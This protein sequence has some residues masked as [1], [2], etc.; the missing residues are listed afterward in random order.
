MFDQNE[1]QLRL[2]PTKTG[3]K[4]GFKM[5]HQ[6]ELILPTPLRSVREY[7][8]VTG[9]GR[10]ATCIIPLSMVWAGNGIVGDIQNGIAGECMKHC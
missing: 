3:L 7:S 2:E 4:V 1:A 8:S 5:Q 6:L 9:N 10:L